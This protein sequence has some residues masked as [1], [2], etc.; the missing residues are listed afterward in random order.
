MKK[1]IIFI[2]LYSLFA[3]TLHNYH[4]S[5]TKIVF[6]KK[7]Q[8]VQVT[9]RY[10]VDDIESTL[11]KKTEKNLELGTKRED[12]EADDVI[13]NYILSHFN[14]EIDSKS[15]DLTYLGKEVDKDIIYF[16]LESENIKTF[17]E[18]KIENTLLL[19]EFDDQQNVIKIK[20]N[21]KTNMFVLKNGNSKKSISFK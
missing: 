3:F 17:K 18:I 19:Q 5:N 7:E 13:I 14:L 15:T 9:M 12:I 11:N 10:F 1:I 6:N 16:Y 2:T 4:L 21:D 20:T 8:A